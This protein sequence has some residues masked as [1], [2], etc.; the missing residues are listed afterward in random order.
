[1]HSRKWETYTKSKPIRSETTCNDCG[2]RCQLCD[3]FD[4]KEEEW[5]RNPC[6][7]CGKRQIIFKGPQTQIEFCKWLISEQHR[8]VTAIAHNARAYDAYFCMNT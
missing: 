5:K 3:K 4:K 1:M 8:Y 2:S 7:G 6:P